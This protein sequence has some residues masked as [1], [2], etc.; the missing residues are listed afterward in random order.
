M[1]C[2]SSRIEG[3]RLESQL[4]GW[5]ESA[6]AGLLECL[7]TVVHR[8]ETFFGAFCQGVQYHLLDLGWDRRHLLTQ[9]RRGHR[10]VLHHDLGQGALKGAA[11]AEPFVDH[12]G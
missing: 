11:A 1:V 6:L 12:H 3:G 7:G 2:C 9:G 8:G 4:S 10:Q 5:C